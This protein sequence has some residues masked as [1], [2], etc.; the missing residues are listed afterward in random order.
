M[1]EP[2]A[3]VVVLRDR[4]SPTFKCL[5]I[6]EKN[7]PEAHETI[8]LL[9]T[10]PEK[11]KSELSAAFPKTR[12]VFG[13]QLQNPAELRNAGLRLSAHRLAV[14]MDNDVFVRPG[15]L[16]A[17][18]RCQ[19]ETGA[20]M[21]MPLILESSTRI[22]TAGNELLFT[23]KDGVK[24]GQK[25]LRYAKLTHWKDTEL[26]RAPVDYA[27]LHCQLVVRET[28]LRLG[29]FDEA[30]REVGEVDSGL[31][32][33]KAGEKMFFEPTSVVQYDFPERITHYEDVRPYLYKWDM[34]E[35]LKGYE[36][37]K[38]K[39]GMDIGECGAWKHFNIVFLNNVGFLSRLWPVPLTL[40]VDNAYH[41]AKQAIE[42]P[43]EG[44]RS[45]KKAS[46]G[47]YKWR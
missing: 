44:W 37:F 7:T 6:L 12:F 28:A 4:F 31:T 35:I 42:I 47:F 1:T 3:I 40:L 30:L 19:S 8:A 20:A 26:K 18:V 27:E 24:Y 43:F 34:R 2:V 17:M 33:A 9:P 21:V 45:L 14:L 22:H 25:V 41:G 15:W 32:W 5:Q 23:Y 46:S 38:Q 16:S 36:Y 29:V 13:P 39:W 11:L 10:A